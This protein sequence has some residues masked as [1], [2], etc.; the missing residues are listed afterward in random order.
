VKLGVDGTP[1]VLMNAWEL[2]E[3]PTLQVLERF[4]TGDRRKLISR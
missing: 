2:H 1:T 3:A 4:I